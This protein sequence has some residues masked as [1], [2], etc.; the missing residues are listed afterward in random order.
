VTF[1]LKDIRDRLATS[2]AIVDAFSDRIYPETAPQGAS[3][4][5]IHIS[6]VSS[7]PE[8]YLGGEA[9]LHVSKVQLDVWTDGTGG[10]F[11]ANELSELVRN[12]LSGYKGQFGTGCHGSAVLIR[13]DPD[14]LPPV[15]GS[16]TRNLRVSMDFEITHSASV[17]TFT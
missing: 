3:F 7:L 6:D 13:N 9:G 1:L 4:P 15:D 8:Y 2:S 11:R 16:D 14:S 10:K 17:P 5:R 12:R